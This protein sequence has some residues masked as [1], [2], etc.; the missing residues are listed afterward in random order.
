MQQGAWGAGGN[1]SAFGGPQDPAG[2]E[3]RGHPHR[4]LEG[5]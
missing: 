1:Q 3:G 4:D 5:W 2:A